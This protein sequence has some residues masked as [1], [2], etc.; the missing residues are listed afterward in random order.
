MEKSKTKISAKKVEGSNV[1]NALNIISGKWKGIIIYNLLKYKILRFSELQKM[2]NGTITQRMLTMQL[3][4]MEEQGIISRN[5]YPTVPPKVEYYLTDK[6]K[7]LEIIIQGL[8]EW[9]REFC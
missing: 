2:L 4:S 1:E 3:R 7:S 9:G 8:H 5:I 6:G